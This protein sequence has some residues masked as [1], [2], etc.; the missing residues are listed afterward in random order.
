[1]NKPLGEMELDEGGR[2]VVVVAVVENSE[3]EE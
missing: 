3:A 1:M 2:V